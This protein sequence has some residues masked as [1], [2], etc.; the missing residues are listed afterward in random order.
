MSK[1][2]PKQKPKQ[3]YTG[4][5]EAVLVE[6]ELAGFEKMTF[7]FPLKTGHHVLLCLE[8]FC[9]LINRYSLLREKAL[10]RFGYPASGGL[11]SI[12]DVVRGPH[13][14]QKAR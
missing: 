3:D 12:A 13:T 1:L 2:S 6:G 8:K 10:P 14:H 9:F 7:P 5:A 11:A 4:V